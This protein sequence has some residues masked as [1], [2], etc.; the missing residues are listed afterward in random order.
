VIAVAGI[1]MRINDRAV[2]HYYGKPDVFARYAARNGLPPANREDTAKFLERVGTDAPGVTI[3]IFVRRRV[4]LPQLGG[5]FDLEFPQAFPSTKRDNPALTLLLGVTKEWIVWTP[6]GYYDTSIA[7]DSRFLGWH[8]NP[9]HDSVRPSDFVPIITYARTMNRPEILDQLWRLGDPN[10]VALPAGK[11]PDGMAVENQ[12][13]RILVGS[14]E[15][16]IRLPAPG[17]VWAVT[18]PNPRLKLKIVAEGNSR[19]RDRRIILDE[20][21]ILT[22]KLANP[23][24]EQT[25][26]L[27]LELSPNRRVRLA[28]EA[29]N[30]NGSRRT[31]AI[32]LVYLPPVPPPVRPV[33]TPR[34]FVVS[35]GGDQFANPQLLPVKYAGKDADEI[36]GFLANHLVSTDGT[37]TKVESKVV[38]SGPLA[39]ANT[40][41]VEFD[42]LDKLLKKKQFQ[43]G[44]IV[45]VVIDSHVLE[46]D[47]ASVIA[48]AD[49]QPGNPPAHAVS[50]REISDLLGQLTDYGCRVVLFLDGVHKLDPRLSSE[51]KPWVRELFLERRVITFVAS[52]N[53]PSGANDLEQRGYFA[54]G[55][56]QALQGDRPPGW[57]KDR[58]AAITLDQFDKAV[59]DTVSKLSAR[60]QDAFSYFPEEVLPQTLFAKP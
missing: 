35:I 12:P 58:T 53:M 13:P 44:D 32:D 49:T 56:R 42:H 45:A 1:G 41:R 20:R 2:T 22:A 25:E 15:G 34:L 8:T 29:T 18:V 6:Q 37:K 55:I 10:L 38:L 47:G 52:E 43:A 60:A 36:T 21:V 4:F 54:L 31:E 14:I 11:A 9:P 39:T 17:V 7:G 50:T 19:V 16:G 28:V 24:S 59:R 3:G 23:I 30:E 26:E 51:I 57:P 5:F 40:V 46:F 27:P 33:P 48:M